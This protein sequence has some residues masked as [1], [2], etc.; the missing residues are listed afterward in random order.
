V[1]GQIINESQSRAGV[2][3]FLDAS[4]TA[5]PGIGEKR[6]GLLSKLGTATV[7]DLLC[8]FPRGYEDRRRMTPISELQDG[9]TATIE[10]QVIRAQ[11]VRL[12]RRQ[13]LAVAVLADGTGSIRATWFGRGFLANTF[14]PGTR[15]ILT[16]T[17]GRYKGLAL[18][19]P[20]YEALSQDDEDVL[21][22]GRIVPVYRLTEGVTQRMLR[23]C[24]FTAL[25][26]IGKAEYAETLPSELLLRHELLPA[27]EAIRAVHFP[28]EMSQAEAARNRF[29]YEE[30][31][32]VQL[33]VLMARS[34]RI[35]KER[36]HPHNVD[37]PALA[38]LR[39]ALPFKLTPGQVRAV[40]DILTD[41]ASPR[42]MLRLL[43]G[44]VGCG[45]TVVALHAIAAA[46]DG[47]FQAALMAP[48]EILAEQHWIAL[49]ELLAPLHLRV[50]LLTGSTKDAA[51]VRESAAQGDCDVLVG[52][53][54]LIQERSAFHRLGLAII[55]EQHRFGVFQRSALVDKGT[56]PDVLQMT[57]TPIPRTLA[58]TVYGGMDVSV[59]E[60]MPTGRLPVKTRTIGPRKAAD[61]YAYIRDQAQR[62]FQT[63]IICPLVEESENRNHKAVVSHY[64]E[65]SAGS[66]AGLRTGLIH[67]RMTGQEKEDVMHRFK[68]GAIDVLFATS[69]IEVG[70]DVPRV[71]TMVVEDAGSFGL[72]QLHQ[73]R[74]R[75][76]RGT[77]QAY[78]FLLGKAATPEGRRR[79]ELLCRFSSGFDIAEEDL[80]LRGPGEFRG[81]RQAGLSDLR[82]ADLVG[83]VRLLDRA[84]RDAQRLLARDPTLDGPELASLAETARRFADLNP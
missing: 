35:E 8:H 74:G 79:I 73:L 26:M 57:A 64:E 75:V 68:Q 5:I 6:A 27:S 15:W 38:A 81:V 14:A 61:L 36:G 70:I 71:T 1:A 34:R 82:V 19:N 50:A 9:Q 24:V 72:T 7:R 29:A 67:G 77:E 43:Q 46:V 55:D 31:V 11:S 66:L 83:D 62:G 60:D 49:R 2:P 12:R 32:G 52:T 42:P 21:N 22:T 23:R 76:G 78:C 20:E 16:G 58:I 54:A 63:Y 4:V 53:H 84:R 56:R 10:A 3:D 33:G 65:L 47:G 59:I 39:A 69:V 40:A 44:D 48:T 41:M 51:D 18:K 30:L 37:G 17:V 25:G 28:S 45:K 13:T 80:K